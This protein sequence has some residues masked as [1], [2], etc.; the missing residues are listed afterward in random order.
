MLR[1]EA[2]SVAREHAR[3]QRLKIPANYQAEA[4]LTNEEHFAQ[5]E[6]WVGPE[7][8]KRH[9]LSLI[10]CWQVVFTPAEF[11][12]EFDP[13]DFRILDQH[14]YFSVNDQSGDCQL[15]HRPSHWIIQTLM[16]GS[17]SFLNCLHRWGVVRE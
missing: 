6:N 5:L 12:T 2:I 16:Q 4:W 7:S 9:L 17:F 1:S 10:G 11:A 3:E 15:L 13:P 8:A 14:F